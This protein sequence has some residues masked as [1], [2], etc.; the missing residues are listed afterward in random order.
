MRYRAS[1]LHVPGVTVGILK[2]I[3]QGWCNTKPQPE[4]SFHSTGS[5]QAT[6]SFRMN[7]GKAFQY[8]DTKQHRQ[9]VSSAIHCWAVLKATNQ[10]FRCYCASPIVPPPGRSWRLARSAAR[11]S[12]ALL[13]AAKRNGDPPSIQSLVV[14]GHTV[15]VHK[16]MQVTIIPH[17][18]T[19]AIT[20]LNPTGD[21]DASLL[22]LNV[23]P[24][25]SIAFVMID[26]WSQRRVVH[27]VLS[28]T[29]HRTDD[30]NEARPV[31]N[32]P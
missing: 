18:S 32:T 24:N 12:C 6:E 23:I 31:P 9:I 8:L 13:S 1:G 10:D 4:Y 22:T 25:T 2:S 17:H 5:R 15:A 20:V 30:D 3:K 7:R 29:V 21:E 14:L 16:T 19:A 27:S 28:T 11:S 26:V